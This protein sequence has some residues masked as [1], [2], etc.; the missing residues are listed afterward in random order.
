[1]TQKRHKWTTVLFATIVTATTCPGADHAIADDAMLEI[2]GT[3]PGQVRIS[4]SG[5]VPNRAMGVLF[6]FEMGEVT[7]PAILP[8]S[9]TVIGVAGFVRPVA[10]LQT[11]PN[12]EGMAIGRA[13]GDFCGGYIQ[14]AISGQHPCQ[15]S[16]VVQVPE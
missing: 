6:G 9:G 7:I 11:G 1:M 3:C 14:L 12:G 16:N 13:A 5:A 15:L 10:R 4:W 2:E 8:C